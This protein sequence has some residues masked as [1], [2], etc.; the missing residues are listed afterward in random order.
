V[1]ETSTG[2]KP[3]VI[4]QKGDD[5]QIRYFYDVSNLYWHRD[6]E[7]RSVTLLSEDPIEIQLDNG[8]PVTLTHTDSLYIPAMA[9]H[10]VI[11]SKPFR[12]MI[13]FL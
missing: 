10:R 7:D 6:K 5:Y 11:A 3:Y 8:L 12:V 13:R 9:F 1:A 2:D 4:N